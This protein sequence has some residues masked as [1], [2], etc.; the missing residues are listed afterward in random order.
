[1]TH[2]YTIG[3]QIA[4]TIVE[5]HNE[6]YE[7]LRKRDMLSYNELLKKEGDFIDCLRSYG[8]GK[9]FVYDEKYPIVF[10]EGETVVKADYANVFRVWR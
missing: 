1:M 7:A 4:D 3:Q 2:S 8:F 6:R 5:I 10:Y 9:S